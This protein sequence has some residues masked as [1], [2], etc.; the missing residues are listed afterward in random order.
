MSFQSD[1]QVGVITPLTAIPVGNWFCDACL[2][3]V[4]EVNFAPEGL[5]QQLAAAQATRRSVRK[6]LK[7]R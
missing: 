6:T 1:M 3:H 2:P 4:D 7:R 5:Q